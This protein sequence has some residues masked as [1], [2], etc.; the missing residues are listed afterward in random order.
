MA[1]TTLTHKL[2]N[3][4]SYNNWM[5][6]WTATVQDGNTYEITPSPN[7]KIS[8]NNLDNIPVNK[9]ESFT[10]TTRNP[11]LTTHNVTITDPGGNEYPEG[12][13]IAIT[14]QDGSISEW[15]KIRSPASSNQFL[16]EQGQWITP[17]HPN[18]TLEIGN[19]SNLKKVP[20]F[21]KKDDNI[22]SY[23]YLEVGNGLQFT[24]I[25]PSDRLLQISAS[26]SNLQDLS[27]VPSNPD[28]GQLLRTNDTDGS[29][30][31]KTPIMKE[32]HRFDF[33]APRWG[34]GTFDEGT[35]INSYAI[36]PRYDSSWDTN[37]EV[38]SGAD[39]THAYRLIIN[40]KEIFKYMLQWQ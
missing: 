7:W 34:H 1:E 24:S 36:L 15:A 32:E 38:G 30:E 2:R 10:D 20:I 40:Q 19:S 16:N 29:L 27:D 21:L 13:H 18:Y 37:N 9:I 25:E 11:Q 12:S 22:T 8:V 31:W 5:D 23:F 26:I 17:T 35:T 4:K 14:N 3:P 33:I 39:K 6:I 28:K